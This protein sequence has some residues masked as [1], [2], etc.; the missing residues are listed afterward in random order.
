MHHSVHELDPDAPFTKMT[1]VTLPK[2]TVIWDGKVAS[3][4]QKNGVKLRGGANQIWIESDL[5]P[6]WFG[7]TIRIK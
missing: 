7:K 4:I 5:D 6:S 2:G 3:Q 1:E